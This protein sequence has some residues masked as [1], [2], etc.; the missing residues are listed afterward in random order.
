M[1]QDIWTLIIVILVFLGVLGL[2]IRGWRNRTRSQAGLFDALPEAPAETGDVILGPLTGVYIGST[3]AGDWQARIARA[4]LGHRSAGTLT[5]FTGGLR[6]DLADA[7]V[8]IPRS[9]LQTVRRASALANKT[10]P[11]G[12]ILIA[13]WQVAG[14]DGTTLIDSGFRADD[15]DTYPRWEELRGDAAPTPRPDTPSSTTE[16]NK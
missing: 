14:P 5:A 9:D 7:T 16:E 8:W 4:P 6:L 15:K 10:V 11:G 12:G 13:R 1:T 2:M 3:V